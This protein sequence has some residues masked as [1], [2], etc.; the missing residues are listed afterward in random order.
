MAREREM[1]RAAKILGAAATAPFVL[2]TLGF[3][4]LPAD[5]AGH[6]LDAQVFYG[7]TALTFLGAVHWGTAIVDGRNPGRLWR[8]LGW[9]MLPGLVAWMAAMMTAVPM[10]VTLMAGIGVCHLV[11]L[12]ARDRGELPIWYLALRRWTNAVAVLSLGASL[13]R[14]A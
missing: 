13:L 4:L 10:L 14:L 6:A 2:G 9:S 3:W 11:D 8:R 1:P 5:A 7:V 12:R